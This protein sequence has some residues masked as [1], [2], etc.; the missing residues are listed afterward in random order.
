[1]ATFTFRDSSWNSPPPG[2]LADGDVHVWLAA[3]DQPPPLLEQ[4]ARTLSDDERT[5][6]ERFRFEQHRMRFVVRR[7]L[8]R[9][10]LGSYLNTDPGR[11]R[12]GYGPRGKPSLPAPPP[13]QPLHFN[14]SHSQ[15]LALYAVTR[16]R[17]IGVDIECV[18]P[19]ADV[20]AMAQQFFSA[21]ENAALRAVPPEQRLETFFR[22]WSCKEAYVKARGDG[23]ALPL[24]QFDIILTSD[25]PPRVVDR[26]AGEAEPVRSWTL[27]EL[28][29][30]PGCAAALVVEGPVGRL[31]CW[32]WQP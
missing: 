2:P 28:Q 3:L 22:F 11:L 19:L 17:E 9:T 21:Q 32:R 1:M 30:A 7:G 13:D 20:E 26:T 16:G 10:I 6:A 27:R 24:D 14:L 12:F 4:L 15:G 25:E 8:L 31:A 29:P 5:R 18:R 23:L